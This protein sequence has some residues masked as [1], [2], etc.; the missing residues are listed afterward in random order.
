MGKELNHM[1]KN[2]IYS[3]IQV[4]II[5]NLNTKSAVTSY[6]FTLLFLS[7]ETNF[8]NS[9]NSQYSSLL[10]LYCLIPCLFKLNLSNNLYYQNLSPSAYKSQQYDPLHLKRLDFLIILRQIKPTTQ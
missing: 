1:F 9:K 2:S 6:I 10:N 7:F 4:K 5:Q 3:T 8:I